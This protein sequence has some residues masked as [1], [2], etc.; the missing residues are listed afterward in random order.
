MKRN[1]GDVDANIRIMI[2]FFLAYFYF[3]NPH[4]S[5]LLTI[6]VVIAAILMLTVIVGNCPFYRIFHINTCKGKA[7]GECPY[8]KEK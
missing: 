3:I 7:C 1:I 8:K 6:G 5:K 4:P 2:S